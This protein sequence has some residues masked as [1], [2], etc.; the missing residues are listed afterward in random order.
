MHETNP[1][2]SLFKDFS[3]PATVTGALAAMVGFT[4]SFAVVLQGLISVGASTEQAASA[5]MALCISMGLCGVLLSTLYRMPISIAWSTPGGAMLAST[6]AIDGGFGAAVGAFIVCAILL[7][8]AGFWKPLAKLIAAIPTPL[9]SAMLAGILFGLCLAPVKAV[10]EFP[11]YALPIFIAW[12][13]AGKLHKLLAVPAALLAF[14]VVLFFFVDIAD[15]LQTLQTEPLLT[16]LTWVA[17]SFSIA[18]VVGITIRYHRCVLSVISTVWWSRGKPCGDNSC[19]V[20]RRR[21]TP[22][23]W[24]ALLVSDSGG[25]ELFDDCNVCRRNNQAG[26]PCPTYSHPSG[27]RACAYRCL[28]RR[29]GCRV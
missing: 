3:I 28:C 12:L 17:P 26:N 10:A 8:L 25:L 21:R 5:L 19:H 2:R 15:G 20:C 13:V 1:H 27:C 18:A 11:L 4:G 7:T 23:S 24:Q 14:F 22:R 9:A 6:S 16:S 29:S